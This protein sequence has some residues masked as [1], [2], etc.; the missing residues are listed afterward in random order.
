MPV[1][2]S[3]RDVRLS[4][5]AGHCVPV[6][7]G[8]PTFIPDPLYE[9][10]IAAGL[11]ITDEPVPAGEKPVIEAPVEE[12]DTVLTVDPLE[13]A[14]RTILERNDENDFKN[15][16]VPKV[17]SVAAELPKGCPK[18]TATEVADVYARLQDDIDLVT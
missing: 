4:N 6:P 1:M 9:D 12:E 3:L 13:Q 5:T 15:D 10:A 17:Y 11:I 14:V 18:P 7:G 16:G 8:V 2:K